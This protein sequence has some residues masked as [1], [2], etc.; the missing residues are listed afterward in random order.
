M[1]RF[2]KFLLLLIAGLSYL[3]SLFVPCMF[4]QQRFIAPGFE[5][6]FEILGL[7]NFNRESI[8]ILSGILSA[9][10]KGNL[11]LGL[12]LFAFTIVLPVTKHAL[13][14]AKW[15]KKTSTTTHWS[16]KIAIFSI[17][18]V[19]V[20]ALFV[21]AAYRSDF[22]EIS[23]GPAPFLLLLSIVTLVLANFPDSETKI[24]DEVH[25]QL[26]AENSEGTASSA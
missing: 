7:A 16:Q 11:G 8:T 15:I 2:N 21:L 3:A 5:R 22:L 9:C 18:D 12:I 14:W 4:V 1:N 25:C 17:L 10:E 24:V 26:T 19:F 23:V 6:L 13:S 20:L